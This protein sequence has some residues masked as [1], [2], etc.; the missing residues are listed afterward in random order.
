MSY[1][2]IMSYVSFVMRALLR[3][4]RERQAC[5]A[6]E[7]GD[8]FAPSKANAHLALLCSQK[9][10]QREPCVLRARMSRSAPQCPLAHV[11]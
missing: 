5:R 1:N 4:R 3:M 9:I 6:A 11:D 10:A 7:S 8:E 2:C